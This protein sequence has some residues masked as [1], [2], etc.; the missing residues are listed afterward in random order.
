MGSAIAYEVPHLTSI[1][2]DYSLRVKR[3]EKEQVKFCI[4]LFLMLFIA[5]L[6]GPNEKLPVT[7]INYLG[8]LRI[9]KSVTKVSSKISTFGYVKSKIPLFYLVAQVF[10]PI[11]GRL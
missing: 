1:L 6:S 10:N 8:A 5:G 9:M 2:L 3:F 4:I 11:Q 7:K